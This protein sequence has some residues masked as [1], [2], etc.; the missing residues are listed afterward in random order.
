MLVSQLRRLCADWFSS[1]SWVWPFR[2]CYSFWRGD[3]KCAIIASSTLH[4][5]Q[6]YVLT[7]NG[8]RPQSH[9]KGETKTHLQAPS[10]N[11]NDIC[12]YQWK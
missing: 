9:F 7:I 6:R 4:Q 8:C 11:H 10:D 3:E 2:M 5:K 12:K 1:C